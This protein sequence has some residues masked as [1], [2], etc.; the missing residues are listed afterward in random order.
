MKCFNAIYTFLKAV[1]HILT[2]SVDCLLRRYTAAMP[3]TVVL[4][5][6]KVFSMVLSVHCPLVV[7]GG[8]CRLMG[9]LGIQP[10]KS[11]WNDNGKIDQTTL[12]F[13]YNSTETN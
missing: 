2:K 3:L 9:K 7:G 1:S 11:N 13:Q 12:L 6:G 5:S 10:P 4:M 8:C